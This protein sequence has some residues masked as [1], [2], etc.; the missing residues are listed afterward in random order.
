MRAIV[1]TQLAASCRPRPVARAKVDT[2]LPV[3]GSL[4]TVTKSLRYGPVS[5]PPVN[6]IRCGIAQVSV[7]NAPART[8]AKIGQKWR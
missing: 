5:N 3:L 1:E 8:L 4:E 6:G 2:G 7:E